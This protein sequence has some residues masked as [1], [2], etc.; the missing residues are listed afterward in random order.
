MRNDCRIRINIQL[1]FLSD[2]HEYRS[3]DGGA[4]QHSRHEV[5]QAEMT[6]HRVD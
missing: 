5:A 3:E 4:D 6:I 1:S 2:Q